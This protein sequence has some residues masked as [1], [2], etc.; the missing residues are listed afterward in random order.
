VF[1][2]KLPITVKFFGLFTVILA[3]VIFVTALAWRD[4]SRA[5][6]S[7]LMLREGPFQA[8]DA[9]RSAQRDFLQLRL[10]L[11]G[12]GVGKLPPRYQERVQAVR[13]NLQQFVRLSTNTAVK[14]HA[15]RANTLLAEWDML[16]REGGADRAQRLD[17][18]T[19]M[20]QADIDANV[21]GARADA[22]DA[23]RRVDQDITGA[24][25]LIAAEGVCIIVFGFVAALLVNDVL[26]LLGHA[27]GHARRIASG[28]LDKV[29]VVDRQ[30][31]PGQLLAAL[32]TMRSELNEQRDA[33][34]RL[35][36]TDTLTG[37]PNRRKLEEV[38]RLQMAR[39]RR[40]KEKLSVVVVDV[41]HFKAVN[42]T[43]GHQVGDQILKHVANVLRG[44]VRETDIVGRWGGEEFLVICPDTG[45]DAAGTVAEKLRAALAAHKFPVV[46]SKTASFGVA[47]LGKGEPLDDA[48]HRADEALYQA[49]ENG[50]NR[51]E[52]AAAGK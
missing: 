33:L 35:A 26:R 36:T 12:K 4:I 48:V 39:V 52:L 30:D 49:K 19:D 17:Q 24:A 14:T 18:L 34:Q 22:D 28:D 16:V 40:F 44:T 29:I 43:H 5:N 11:S 9:G 41:D 23:V 37:L 51:V 20:I 46:G 13:T 3:C 38:S 7:V 47:Q 15:Q 25:A 50:R 10:L 2:N 27:V 21:E 1:I 32:E 8:V 31:E 45:L 42:D 6:T